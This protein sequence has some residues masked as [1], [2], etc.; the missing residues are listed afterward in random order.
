[1]TSSVFRPV[2]GAYGE[3]GGRYA[4]ELLHGPLEELALAHR[5]LLKD[6]SF[7][8]ELDRELATWGGRP[9]PITFCPRFSE[10]A[11]MDVYLKREDL[12]HGGAHK[13]NNVV[14]Q[15]LLAKVLGKTRL[16]AETGAG[17]HGVACALAGA[18]HGLETVIFMGSVDMDRQRPNVRLMELAGAKVVP[19]TAGG[20]TLKE[21]VNA[22]LRAWTASVETTHYVL[23]SVC[24]PDPFPSLV[25]SLQ[26]VIGRE[27]RR[28]FEASP[29]GLPD[30]VIACVGG[31]SNAI[32]IF[33]AFLQDDVA[34]VG[35][36]AGGQGVGS[37]RHGA[38]LT[39]GRPGLLHGARTLVLQDEDGQTSDAHSLAAGLDY[40]GVGPEHAHL[41]ATGR[42][43]YVHATDEETLE[44]FEFLSRT[45]GIVPAFE[46]AHALAFCLRAVREGSLPRGRRVLVNLSGSG[47]K[48]LDTYFAEYA[49]RGET[50]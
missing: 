47:R 7:Q 5:R 38:T 4:S 35:V 1:M 33:R 29:G 31:G 26:S 43:T 48:D 18:R 23:G 12:L 50:P 8:E 15:A 30:A 16:I 39:A 17:Q 41:A 36:E 21:A 6:P 2:L 13:T 19:V 45:E 28:Q 34:L 20:A 40:P 49:H 10:A 27:A 14:G 3:F 25:A 22:A 32:G 46:S 11:Q 9:T 42:V 24:G 37:G 44:A